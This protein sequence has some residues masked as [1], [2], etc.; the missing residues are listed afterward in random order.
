MALGHTHTYS[1]QITN[2]LRELW[3]A[4]IDRSSVDPQ[5]PCEG[6][7][8]LRQTL[9]RCAHAV[10]GRWQMARH[11]CL[12]WTL[13]A[14]CASKPRSRR[15]A[16]ARGRAGVEIQGRQSLPDFGE[17]FQGI[18]SARAAWSGPRRARQSPWL[19]AVRTLLGQARRA[20]RT[21]ALYVG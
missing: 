10:A 12:R 3:P 9:D 15:L 18:H 21:A 4:A 17:Q 2:Q 6:E 11:A 7:A 16:A 5:N 8:A 19:M 13:D 14:R 1:S 20:W